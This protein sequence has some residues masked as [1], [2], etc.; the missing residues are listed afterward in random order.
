MEFNRMKSNIA[1]MMVLNSLACRKTIIVIMLEIHFCSTGLHVFI[2]LITKM[3]I[4][5]EQTVKQQW[6]SSKTKQFAGNFYT[7]LEKNT[8]FHYF[9]RLF[10]STVSCL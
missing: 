3:A 5:S 8:Y 4:N 9:G 10:W 7:N 1:V 6:I 2:V